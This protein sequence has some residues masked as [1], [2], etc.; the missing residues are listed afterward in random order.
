MKQYKQM[1]VSVTDNSKQL[2]EGDDFVFD[3]DFSNSVKNIKSLVFHSFTFT[4]NHLRVKTPNDEF[5]IYILFQRE[6]AHWLASKNPV[7]NTPTNPPLYFKIVET[8]EQTL[9]PIGSA[10]SRVFE[11]RKYATYA[12]PITIKTDKNYTPRQFVKALNE[13]KKNLASDPNFPLRGNSLI[14]AQAEFRILN[15]SIQFYVNSWI[16]RTPDDVGGIFDQT[17]YNIPFD[18]SITGRGIIFRVGIAIFD[19]NNPYNQLLGF[20]ESN[21]DI[22]YVAFATKAIGEDWTKTIINKAVTAGKDFNFYYN[23]IVNLITNSCFKPS[24]RLTMISNK[25][26][27]DVL[28]SVPILTVSGEIFYFE[29]RFLANEIV[30]DDIEDFKLEKIYIK[31]T[32]E[33]YEPIKYSGNELCTIT[34]LITVENRVETIEK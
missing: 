10:P 9:T 19:R 24:D 20:V 23:S 33:F 4:N 14:G 32:D 11:Q 3:I 25:N 12:F 27:T 31:L 7:L 6:D 1:T 2:K 29:N 8:T 28:Y 5:T 26:K 17:Q 15:N 22:P 13:A 34:F 18:G 16:P 30:Y 21:D